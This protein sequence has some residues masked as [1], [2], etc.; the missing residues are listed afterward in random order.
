MPKRISPCE[1]CFGFL[2]HPGTVFRFRPFKGG[3]QKKSE[4]DRLLTHAVAE[5]EIDVLEANSELD[6]WLIV[7]LGNIGPKYEDTR[8][9]VGFM[10]IDEFARQ[11][12]ISMSKHR[13]RATVGSALIEGVPVLLAKPTTFMNNSGES[14]IDATRHYE[15]PKERVL[16][17]YDDL[18]L[19]TAAVR[20]RAK[21]GHGG[22][23]GMRSI[24]A[25]L[26]GNDFPRLKI[27]IGRPSGSK[28]IF[29]HVLEPFGETDKEEIDVA[30]QESIDKIRAILGLGIQK[31]LSGVTLQR[32]K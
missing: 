23:N 16:V 18:D 22:H 6:S 21:G 28:P 12:G 24:V 5:K 32:S 7:G 29:Q 9:N 11:E 13:H 2:R 31:A 4:T 27:G 15:I 20:L 8:H 30:I 19:P 3:R 17:V 10:V 25:Q 26:G 1:K 14:V